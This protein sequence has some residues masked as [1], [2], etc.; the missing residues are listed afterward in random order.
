MTDYAKRLGYGGSAE[1][2]GVQTLITSGNFDTAETPSYL[3]ALDIPPNSDMR[4]RILHA[5]GVKSYSGSVGFD[6]SPKSM[7]LFT[8]SKLLCRRYKFSVG[9]H[10]GEDHQ[11]MANCYANSV[12][13]NA[14]PG[15][16]IAASVSFMGPT[17]PSAVT[18]VA[19]SYTG[20]VAGSPDSRP[21]GYWYSGNTNVRDWSL[22]MTQD[23]IPVYG[24]KSGMDPLY[25]RVGL[26]NYSL[27]VTTFEQLYAYTTI[28]I[29]T[30]TFTLAGA[31]T[32]RGY[33]FGG[34][35]DLGHYTHTFET[36]AASTFASDEIVFS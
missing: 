28:S 13:L 18:S 26:V 36:A 8:T 5:D 35:N 2:D 30:D 10:D 31:T 4:G 16:L 29:I 32:A 1:I 33:S 19:N 27:Q 20:F 7:A 11:T 3:N 14:S 6:V 12:S 9:I 21:T 34:Q 23:V 15:G 24:N 17:A 25:L 22:T